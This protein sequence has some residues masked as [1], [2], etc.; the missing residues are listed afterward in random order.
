M[1]FHFQLYQRINPGG[2]RAITRHRAK[3]PTLPQPNPCTR[4]CAWCRSSVVCISVCTCMCGGEQWRKGAAWRCERK[5][6][7]YDVGSRGQ[8]AGSAVC[9]RATRP[10]AQHPLTAHLA[11]LATYPVN[12]RRT[13]WNPK[14]APC[15]LRPL[16]PRS[17]KR[18]DPTSYTLHPIARAHTPAQGLRCPGHHLL[19]V[20]LQVHIHLHHAIL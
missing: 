12:P 13:S 2:E 20:L 7:M 1:S 11:L 6:C 16:Y 8:G 14:S 5:Q 9:A 10:W 18:L 15:A 19:T 4:I 17:K 3:R